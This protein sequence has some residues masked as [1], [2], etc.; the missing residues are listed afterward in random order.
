MVVEGGMTDLLAVCIVI[1][2]VGV[3]KLAASNNVEPKYIQA[4]SNDDGAGYICASL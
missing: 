4:I 1:D 2:V 3:K